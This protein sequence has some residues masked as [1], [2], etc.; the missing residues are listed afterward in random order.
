MRLRSAAAVATLF[1]MLASVSVWAHHS[2]AA[3]YDGTKKIT[4][5]GTVIG[6]V[7][8]TEKIVLQPTASVDGDI[9]TPRLSMAD[10]AVVKGKVDARGNR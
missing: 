7:T 6:N 4:V 3:E 10:G 9:V 2:F 1:L 5:S 8:A